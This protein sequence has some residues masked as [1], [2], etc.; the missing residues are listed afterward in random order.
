MLTAT[1]TL[2]NG[3]SLHLQQLDDFPSTLS[4]V[5]ITQPS[6]YDHGLTQELSRFFRRM[7]VS[8]VKSS[9]LSPITI[10]PSSIHYTSESKALNSGSNAISTTYLLHATISV[11]DKQGHTILGPKSFSSSE[12]LS[13]NSTIINTSARNTLMYSQLTRTIMPS[14]TAWLTSDNSKNTLQIAIEHSHDH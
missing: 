12:T 2:C 4:T 6:T 13:Q 14:I 5:Y 9:A 7:H 3:C 10:T 1:L 11:L 8:I